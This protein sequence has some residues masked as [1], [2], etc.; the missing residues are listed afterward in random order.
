MPV[1]RVQWSGSEWQELYVTGDLQWQVGPLSSP[2]VVDEASRLPTDLAPGYT[3]EVHPAAVEWMRQVSR[4]PFSGAL[5]I[6]DYGYDADEYYSP[7]RSHGTLRRYRHH[8]VD[9]DLLAEL[10]HCDL[11][12]HIPFSRLIDEATTAGLEV[13]RYQDQG[14]FLTHSA[15]ELILSWQ[16]LP[17]AQR[18]QRVRQF[19]SLTHPGHMGRSFRQLWLRKA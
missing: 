10:G 1:H 8:Q 5:L 16:R 3:T 6:A 18:Q 11:T 4:L 13:E 15:S 2:A 9:N 19:Q 7:E 12:S 14:R 17:L